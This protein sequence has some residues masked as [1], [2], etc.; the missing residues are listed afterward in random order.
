M[1]IELGWEFVTL[2]S[3]SSM[4]FSGFSKYMTSQYLRN[5]P[6]SRSFM[7]TKT[8]IKSWF[9]WACCIHIDFRQPCKWCGWDPPILAG[10]GTHVGFPKSKSSIDPIQK[11]Q[12]IPPIETPHR[13]MD[14][15]FLR[16]KHHRDHLRYLTGRYLHRGTPALPPDQEQTRAADLCDALPDSCQAAFLFFIQQGGTHSQLCT[17]GHVLRLV[18][19][20][21]LLSAF[22]PH[23]C[24]KPLQE[25]LNGTLDKDHIT[26]LLQLHS[27][28]VAE[29][30][31]SFDDGELHGAIKDFLAYI[32][33]KE[34]EF[35]G[36]CSRACMSNPRII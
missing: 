29:L 33:Q 10:D 35:L 15:C 8:F 26:G 9:G 16:E 14:R 28:E 4:T 17:L 27:P 6:K 22:L 20:D 36:T 13:R 25:Y 34:H 21:S 1:A 24:L 11:R 32:V 2:V 3:V 31:N 12:D 19:Y 18:S 7:D 30:I 5:N 23:V